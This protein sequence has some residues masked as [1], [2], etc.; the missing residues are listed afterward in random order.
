MGLDKL[1]KQLQKDHGKETVLA[2]E[3][4]KSME[5]ISSFGSISLDVTLGTGGIPRGKI[6]EIYGQPSGGKTLFSLIAV[7]EVQKKGGVVAF[8]DLENSADLDWFT[9]IG[10]NLDEDKFLLLKPSTGES[11]LQMI[12]DCI[13][14]KEIDLIV[15]D[16]ISTLSTEAERESNYGTGTTMAQLAR[17][18]SFGLKKLNAMMIQNPKVTLFLLNQIRES[19]SQYEAPQSTGGKALQHYVDAKLRVSRIGGRDGLLGDKDAP[20]GFRTR[21]HVEKSKIG[22]P[23]RTVEISLYI[24]VE[25]GKIGTDLN[26]EIVD[27]AISIDLIKRMS[28]NKE[29]GELEEN[30]NGTYYIYDDNQFY[31]MPKLKRFIEENPGNIETLKNQ[32]M[33]FLNQ[34]EKPE[35][36]SFDATISGE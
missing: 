26:E 11:A 10:V 16:S 32:V 34:K 8:I 15:L 4:I 29:T 6:I 22:P 25:D 7:A 31:G 20:I 27:V 17:L 19:M 3:E 18:L 13:V 5:I 14:S 28:K 23:K 1:R 12:E 21:V 35:P 24:G 30:S 33:I 2:K 36:D 9:K